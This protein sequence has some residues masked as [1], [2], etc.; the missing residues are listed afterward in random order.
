MDN[1]TKVNT[2][3]YLNEQFD[4][5]IEELKTFLEAQETKAKAEGWTWFE[6]TNAPSSYAELTLYN[7][8]RHLPIETDGNESSVYGRHH[9]LLFRFW[10]DMTHLKLGVS[11]NKKGEYAVVDSHLKDAEA[12]GLSKMA[13]SILYADTKGQID[14]Y[15]WNKRYV[16]NQSDFI[17]IA[18]QR[19]IQFAC[20]VRI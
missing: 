14:Y 8:A 4:A 17:H 11:F 16:N 12:H 13:T 2:M 3:N 20:K 7:E 9:N 5:A 18:L 15:D 19:G 10:H 1:H 6:S